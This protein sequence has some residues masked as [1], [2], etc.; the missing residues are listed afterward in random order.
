MRAIQKSFHWGWQMPQCLPAWLKQQLLSKMAVEGRAPEIRLHQVEAQSSRTNVQLDAVVKMS[1]AK[2]R[3][4][5]RLG[6][7]SWARLIIAT[8]SSCTFVWLNCA[9][10]WSRR[11]SRALPLAATFLTAAVVWSRL[12]SIAAFSALNVTI[13]AS[14]TYHA[15][16]GKTRAKAEK[17]IVNLARQINR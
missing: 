12:A 15:P 11:I 9:S 1:R 16:E 17:P 8:A 4:S 5:P 7:G 6:R 3:I 14:L 10:T 2:E 13:P